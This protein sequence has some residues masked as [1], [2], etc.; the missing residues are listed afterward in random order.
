VSVIASPYQPYSNPS[1]AEVLASGEMLCPR[2][3]TNVDFAL[4]SQRMQVYYWTAV[5][6]GTAT[7]VMTGTGNTAVNAMTYAAIGIYSV[8]SS[9]NLTLLTSTGDLHATLWAST[10]TS[11]TVALTTPF[12]RQEGVR[13]AA[14]V[15]AVAGTA[16]SLYGGNPYQD[17]A[18]LSPVMASLLTGQSVLPASVP[19]GS[20]AAAHWMIATAVQP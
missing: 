12:H 17:F 5:T 4:V 13:Y 16:P 14:A 18:Q 8:D 10:F 3:I 11:Y 2:I 9:G 6:S 7:T 15:L 19:A 1:G 20:L